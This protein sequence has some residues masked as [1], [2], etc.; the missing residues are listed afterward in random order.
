M[1]KKGMRCFDAIDLLEADELNETVEVAVRVTQ[2]F[3][4]EVPWYSLR[5]SWSSFLFWLKFSVKQ[6]RT[7]GWRVGW[8]QSDWNWRGFWKRNTKD[9]ERAE[10]GG[11]WKVGGKKKKKQTPVHVVFWNLTLG[12]F[13]FSGFQFLE[14]K[15]S[16][17]NVGDC[18]LTLF[19]RLANVKS[20]NFVVNLY[21]LIA[22]TKRGIRTLY[23]QFLKNYRQ[24]P[25][26]GVF[27]PGLEQ[28]APQS[29]FYCSSSARHN[30][31]LPL[32]CLVRGESVWMFGQSNECLQQLR[33]LLVSP[34]RRKDRIN[35]Q[36]I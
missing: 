3:Q 26:F 17:R 22:S 25:C 31:Q 19:W 36:L 28:R 13:F 24:T 9:A 2:W 32:P 10:S 18:A 34:R 14:T 5:E 12:R 16:S 29:N 11:L 30:L 35:H 8:V 23:L 15:W 4:W 20:H 7:K 21:A 1:L 6:K 27:S 33:Q